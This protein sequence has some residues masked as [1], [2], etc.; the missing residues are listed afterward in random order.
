M[1]GK[2]FAIRPDGSAGRWLSRLRLPNPQIRKL[3]KS[4]ASQIVAY[5]AKARQSLVRQGVAWGINKPANNP[6]NDTYAGMQ[7]MIAA[8]RLAAGYPALLLAAEQLARQIHLSQGGL[9]GR[10]RQG[11]GQSFWQFRPYI[12]GDDA[13]RIDWRQSAKSNRAFIRETEWE[14]S[15]TVMF[16]CQDDAAMAFQSHDAPRSKRETGLI[17]TLALAMLLAKGEERFGWLARPN[18]LGVGNTGLQQLWQELQ[19][20]LQQEARAE[21]AHKDV[22]SPSPSLSSSPPQGLSLGASLH[23]MPTLPNRMVGSTLVLVG[24][25]MDPPETWQG[26]LAD[27][28]ARRCNGLLIRLVD[29]IERRFPFEE[30]SQFVAPNQSV[31]VVLSQPAAV[32]SAYLIA[33]ANHNQAMNSLAQQYGFRWVEVDTAAPLSASLST[34]LRE[35]QTVGD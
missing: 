7:P 27:W 20:E 4:V 25:F 10:R 22:A 21:S 33:L 28:Q 16:W 1:F 19:Q 14:S 12:D 34:L 18:Q 9:H 13:R 31:E 15:E 32:R 8:G 23:Q 11:T 35:L 5:K 6:A 29:P 2:R 17:L 26:V 24:D 30:A 3:A